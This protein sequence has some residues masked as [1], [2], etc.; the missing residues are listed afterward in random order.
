[1]ALQQL[2]LVPGCHASRARACLP[3][4]AALLEDA[5]VA[6]PRHRGTMVALLDVSYAA[7]YVLLLSIAEFAPVARA[8]HGWRL[9]MT[10]PCWPAAVMLVMLC[11]LPETPSSLIQRGFLTEAKESLRRIRGEFASEAALTQEALDIWHAAGCPTHGCRPKV[12]HRM[13]ATCCMAQGRVLTRPHPPST[14]AALVR[15]AVRCRASRSRCD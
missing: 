5:E 9:L 3:L 2:L 14:R 1:M 10:V 11:F 4:Q 7:G 6:P 13:S 12:W 8:Q 15:C